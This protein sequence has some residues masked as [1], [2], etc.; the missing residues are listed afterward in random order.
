MFIDYFPIADKLQDYT[1]YDAYGGEKKFIIKNQFLNFK[2]IEIETTQ[3]E[4]EDISSFKKNLKHYSFPL[5]GDFSAY[6]T[7]SHEFL[8]A[9]QD[10][11]VIVI[12]TD[13]E[14][15]VP[16]LKF[17]PKTEEDF[18]NLIKTDAR[19]L[20]CID[21]YV[22]ANFLKNNKKFFKSLQNSINFCLNSIKSNKFLSEIEERELIKK[23][24]YQVDIC[25]LKLE[26]NFLRGTKLS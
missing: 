16:K 12:P 17:Q 7:G 14:N 4:S 23:Y 21:F 1:I 2:D 11:K 6:K 24:K 10:D 26:E 19:F 9:R 20:G 8:I 3:V 5:K 25:I 15:L 13:N 22:L 18:I